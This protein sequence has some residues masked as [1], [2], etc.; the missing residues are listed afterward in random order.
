MH[1]RAGVDFWV[2]NNKQAA[3]GILL[4][5]QAHVTWPELATLA[6]IWLMTSWFATSHLRFPIHCYCTLWVQQ[7]CH[8]VEG[9]FS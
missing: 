5:Q 3:V 8:I 4:A 7:R 2:Y 9:D 6:L 1:S